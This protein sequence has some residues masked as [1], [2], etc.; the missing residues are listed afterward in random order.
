MRLGWIA[1]LAGAVALAG[2]AFE[3]PP[4]PNDPA[5]VGVLQPEVLMRNL[6]WA[7]EFYTERKL[8]GEIDDAQLR[9]LL[10]DYAN[11]LVAT[12][13][14]DQINPVSAWKYGDVFRTAERW[15]LA[16]EALVMAVDF[17]KR[18][19]NEDRRVNDSLRLAQVLAHQGRVDEAIQMARST[20]DTPPDQKAPILYAV[21]YEIVPAA[22]RKG[23]DAELAKLLEDA[24][25]QHSQVVVDPN[26]DSGRAF[27]GARRHH[28]SLAWQRVVR[29]YRQA[30]R[31]SE[32]ERAQDRAFRMMSEQQRI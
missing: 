4:D 15:D 31:A 11:Q 18:S 25:D 27:L 23:R 24:I 20:F 13:D 28:L 5:Q 16:E 29:L 14:L 30:G 1:A 7:A 26:S 3:P 9:Q 22:E 21:L 12:V 19:R 6:R 8:R 10:S 2:C 32:A 17:A